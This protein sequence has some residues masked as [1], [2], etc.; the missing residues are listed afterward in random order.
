[1][2]NVLA[3]LAGIRLADDMALMLAPRY[4]ITQVRELLQQSPAILQWELL[5][6]IGGVFLLFASQELPYQWL[7]MVTAGDTI[8]KGTFLSIE[9]RSWRGPVIDY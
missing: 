6:I 1:M 7:R 3:A 5:A 2:D 4:I 8:A 9:T